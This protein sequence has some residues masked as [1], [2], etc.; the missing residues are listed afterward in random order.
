VTQSRIASLSAE[1]LHADDVERLPLHVFFAHIDDTLVAEQGARGGRRHT[2]LTRA[3]LGDDARLIHALGEQY[4]AQGVVD[5]MGTGVRQVFT[6]EIDLCSAEF[7]GHLLGE[8][9]RGGA[10]D[11]VFGVPFQFRLEFGVGLGFVIGE[12]QFIER[13]DDRL[14]HEAPPELAAEPSLRVGHVGVR[15]CNFCIQCLCRHDQSLLFL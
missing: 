7:A 9:E 4:L 14:R 1:Q 6:L 2:M 13:R 3:G 8:K 15:F 10:S 11:I 5:L 12:G